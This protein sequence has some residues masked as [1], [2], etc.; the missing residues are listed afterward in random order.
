MQDTRL[1]SL[2]IPTIGFF[3]IAIVVLGLPFLHP[4]VSATEGLLRWILWGI[5][6]LTL[7]YIIRTFVVHLKKNGL[8]FAM[9]WLFTGSIPKKRNY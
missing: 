2:S 1:L 9:K 7:V 3:L 6:T 4:I 8:K 5:A